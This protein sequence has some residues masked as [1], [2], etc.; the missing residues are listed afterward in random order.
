MN[1]RRIGDIEEVLA[2]NFLKNNGYDIIE[3]NFRCKLGEIDIVAE[4][5]GYLVFVEVKYRSSMQ[6]GS[7]ADSITIKKQER[8]YKVAQLYMIRNHIAVD[9]PT[10]FDVVLI[11]GNEI[12]IIKNAF[13]VM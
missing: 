7:P 9:F 5:E 4:H 3:R 11:L 2:V 1:N 8:I 6:Y 12:S 13:G 10:R